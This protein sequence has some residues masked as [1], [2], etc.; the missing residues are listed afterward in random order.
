VDQ[1]RLVPSRRGEALHSANRINRRDSRHR[2]INSFSVP[3]MPLWLWQHRRYIPFRHLADG[4]RV[5]SFIALTSTTETL[6]DP[7]LRHRPCR[8]AKS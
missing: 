8:P 5:I 4:I 1:N 2:E 7:A 6:F 3:L